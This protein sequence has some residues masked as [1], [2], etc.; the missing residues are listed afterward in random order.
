M[1]RAYICLARN[2]LE[3]NFLQL[4]DLWPNESLRNPIYDGNGQTEYLTWFR[5]NDAVA[6][7]AGP[8]VVANDT[9]YGLRAYLFDSIDNQS[10]GGHLALTVPFAN[11]IA[12]S[13]LT[14]VAAG[15]ALTV[16]AVDAAV[17]AVCAAS[18]LTG[19]TAA[20][21]TSLGSI[22][23]LLRILSGETYRVAAGAAFTTG[24]SV[25]HA[26]KVGVFVTTPDIIRADGTGPDAEAVLYGLP[27][28]QKTPVVQTGTSDLNFHAIRQIVHTGIL[29]M[30]A[31][32]GV[33]HQLKATT[34][35][36]NN[37]SF[38]YNATT[39]TATNAAG[40]RLAT[41]AARAVVVYDLAGNVI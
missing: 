2:D 4:L 11:A 10:T 12:T 41:T 28:I 3:D 25:F 39:G 8:P 5:Q 38:T 7:T 1:S 29:D 22:E 18:D 15:A 24:A 36:F 19:L 33:L 20:G 30:S 27:V 14:M 17:A 34:Y 32:T 21:S 26:A 40:V 35:A 16:A 13:L 37:P 31:A 6:I 9:Y 23:E